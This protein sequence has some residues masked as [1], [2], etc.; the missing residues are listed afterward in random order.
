MR[1][2]SGQV[3]DVYELFA[4]KVFRVPDYQRA[5]AWEPNPH[6]ADFWN[7][8]KEAMMTGTEHYWGT[9]TLRVTGESLYCK[10]TATRFNVHEIVDGQQRITTL[11][12]LLLA[13][14]KW[15][16]VIKNNFIKCEDIYR[17]KLGGLNDQ[18]LRDLVDGRNPQPRIKT[19]KLLK[20]AF[21]YFV[22]QLNLLYKEQPDLLGK[23]PDYL[24]R[25]TFSLE[26]VVQ[27][28]TM[29]VKAFESLNDRG[30]PLTLLDKTKSFLMFYSLRYLNNRLASIINEVFGN[31][32]MNY[33]I[34][35]GIGENQGI[36]YIRGRAFS[37]D[38]VLRFFYHYFAYYAIRK[39]R[40]PTAYNFDIAAEDVFDTFLKE[41]CKH[42][43]D[44]PTRLEEFIKEF[45]EN[46]NKF[47]QA[48]NTMVSRVQTDCQYKK[49]FSFLGLNT[50]LYPLIISLESENIL[51][52][53]MV[54]IIESIE[55]R[56]YKIRGT[57][58]RA[59]LYRN[60]I[61]Q[62]KVKPDASFIYKGL[63]E[64]R[65][66]FMWDDNFRSY[67][68]QP[69]YGNPAV[70]YILWEFEKNQNP[71]FDDCDYNF[72][73]DVQIDHIFPRE[74][75]F[76]PPAYGFQDLFKYY[77]DI[78]K[79]GNL[80]LLEEKINKRVRNRPPQNKISEYQ[81]SKLPETQNLGFHI[82]NRGYSKNDIDSRTKKI[83]DFCVRRW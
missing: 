52:Q 50:R 71:S 78:H 10:E 79:I 19:N 11:Y 55:V 1:S 57:D 5:Y 8:I 7:D 80:T 15:T 38:E 37:E 41:S 6:I 73:K 68:S 49:L 20:R 32:F 3:R 42:L 58:P 2:Y 62:I 63:K 70:K 64:F 24:Q 18:F 69:L 36:D 29:A 76:T 22:H 23:I 48:F 46:L 44:N 65:D 66:E 83:V 13:L 81:S 35:K 59:G 77:L 14:S 82:A 31:V 21:E 16:P 39:Y 53:Q 51:D 56:I 4:G 30:K 67:L 72:Y 61:S 27:D 43:K 28:E 75:T 33:D 12:L 74:A 9:I 40:L 25:A 45:L 54:N 26:F 60:A 47:A 17:L 34:I